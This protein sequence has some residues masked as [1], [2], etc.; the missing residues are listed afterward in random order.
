[1]SITGKANKTKD[2][3]WAVL[4][5]VVIT[6][7]ISVGMPSMAM[8]VLS[9]EISAEL[10]LDLVQVGVVWGAASLPAI[11]TCLV[12]GMIGDQFG[13]KKVLTFSVLLMG[14]VGAARG[15]ATSYFTLVLIVILFGAL[16]PFVTINIMKIIGQLFSTKQL[17]LANGL[18][19]M[20][21]AAGFL[22]GSFLSA[23]VLSPLVGGWRNVLIIYGA[24]GALLCIPWF[25]V[26]TPEL[27][28]QAE[29][30]H[31]PMQKSVL[32]VVR[33]KNMWLLGFLLFGFSGCVQGMLGYIPL[34]L[35]GLGWQGSQ[36]D[37]AVSLFHLVSLFFVVPITILSDRLGSR[38]KLLAGAIIMLM[39]GAGLLSF[40]RGDWIWLA[41]ILAGLIRD[42][43]MALIFTLTIETEGIGPIYAGTATGF[44][45]AI[46][47]I[48]QFIE[49]P[50]GNS[51]AAFRAG[52]PFLLWAGSAAMALILLG[53][54]RNKQKTA[55]PGISE[56]PV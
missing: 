34:Y 42:G 10:N 49:P 26:P 5:L 52:A 1:M 25:F 2:V 3:K 8:T 31:L 23:S 20:G 14:L 53:L 17:G 36:A 43:S 11:I 13:P 33:M 24:A 54:I 37:G 50:L 30:Q 12:G 29:N 9:K 40:V 4:T 22:L 51:L 41:I 19:C 16:L 48:G 39:L 55:L 21:M 7:I 18:N 28:G 56:K 15:L 44:I 45:S 38:K 32:H 46:S 6:S 27:A 35:R 47:Y